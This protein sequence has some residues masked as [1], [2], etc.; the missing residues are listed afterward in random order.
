MSQS[1][2]SNPDLPRVNSD[3][4]D[5]EMKTIPD[6][7]PTDS[8]QYGADTRDTADIDVEVTTNSSLKDESL[9]DEINDETKFKNKLKFL[10]NAERTNQNDTLYIFTT[11]Q[12]VLILLR[13]YSNK[14]LAKDMLLAA[15]NSRLTQSNFN[16]SDIVLA[17]IKIVELLIDLQD[18]N[19]LIELFDKAKSSFGNDFAVT[20]V[21]YKGMN[22]MCDSEG[23]P[24]EDNAFSKSVL[25][26][27][28]S[29][30]IYRLDP[31]LNVMFLSN[32][33]SKIWEE[34][35]ILVKNRDGTYEVQN[36]WAVKYS[37][38]LVNNLRVSMHTSEGISNYL[39]RDIG[40]HFYCNRSYTTGSNQG[41]TKERCSSQFVQ[42][43]ACKTLDEHVKSSPPPIC[44]RGHY[45][46][47]IAYSNLP[48][49]YNRELICYECKVNYIENHASYFFCQNCDMN[50]FMCTLCH[51]K[52]ACINSNMNQILDQPSLP[53]L[54][55][56]PIVG[57][58]CCCIVQ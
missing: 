52:L 37:N 28:P 13:Q 30:D 47:R 45:M 31:R 4:N 2:E 16:H 18:Y 38:I 46:L 51:A 29:M 43:L 27:V 12:L 49:P 23:I 24:N 40:F 39:S 50:Q 42:C 14:V 25:D 53:Q 36:K 58:D 44:S 26:P 15:L 56:E 32:N 55:T 3:F 21:I 11:Y 54:S 17:T 6:K 41:N 8:S 35:K 9:D 34:G 5:E 57:D 10:E 20:K 19:N 1:D 22:L 7:D 48:F 33:N